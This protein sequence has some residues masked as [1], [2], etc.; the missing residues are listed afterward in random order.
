VTQP[1]LFDLDAP[2]GA[3]GQPAART[4]TPQPPDDEA[5]RRDT[6][7]AEILSRLE[8]GPATSADLNLICFRYSARIHELRKRHRIDKE[9]IGG[10]LYR[11]TLVRDNP[12]VRVEGGA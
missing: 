2:R 4:T 7:R 9:S 8:R 11:Y 10:G 12:A 6:Q 1:T 5:A 3:Y